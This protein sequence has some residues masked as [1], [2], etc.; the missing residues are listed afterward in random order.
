MAD[1][2]TKRTKKVQ[3]KENEQPTED[4]PKQ[5]NNVPSKT[6]RVNMERIDGLMNLFEEIVIGRS[7]LEQLSKELGSH[8]LI[9]TVE[10]I[11]RA[12]SD[13]QGLLLNM[14]MVPVAY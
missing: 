14:R 7:R 4:I 5:G 2:V 12:S 11:S 13:M 8:E 10:H 6:I 1:V 3:S 9:E